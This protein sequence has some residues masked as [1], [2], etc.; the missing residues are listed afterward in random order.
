[1][2][3]TGGVVTAL[4]EA[5]LQ[6]EFVHEHP[7]CCGPIFPFMEQGADGWWRITGDPIPLTLSIRARKPG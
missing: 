1:M 6:I 4:I 2:Y 7:V 5:G 3:T